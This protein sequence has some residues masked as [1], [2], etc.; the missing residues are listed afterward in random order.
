MSKTIT[1][2]IP[3]RS[4]KGQTKTFH[5]PASTRVFEQDDSGRWYALHDGERDAVTE[6][7]VIEDCRPAT[8]WKEI[9][10]AHFPMYGFHS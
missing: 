4:M 3:A 2:F 1:A 10:Q 5:Y 7:D 9:R 8:N 6:Q